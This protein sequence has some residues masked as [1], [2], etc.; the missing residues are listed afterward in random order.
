MYQDPR[1][2]QCQ[3]TNNS[4]T[5]RIQLSKAGQCTKAIPKI[6]PIIFCSLYDLLPNGWETL[7]I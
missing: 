3:T 6:F 5:V 7:N 4:L 2:L 1:I